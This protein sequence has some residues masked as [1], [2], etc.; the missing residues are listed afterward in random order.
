MIKDFLKQLLKTFIEMSSAF[1]PS[2]MKV[3]VCVIETSNLKTSFKNST[4]IHL[5]LIL[6][7]Q[8]WSKRKKRVGH[9]LGWWELLITWLLKLQS[10]GKEEKWLIMM[11]LRLIYGRWELRCFNRSNMNCHLMLE[12]WDRIWKY[13]TI[14]VLNQ[15]D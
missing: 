4:N 9:R 15:R 2:Y 14:Q 10:E 1:Y 6:G 12:M 5:W 13:S 3:S 8:S 7:I 11:V